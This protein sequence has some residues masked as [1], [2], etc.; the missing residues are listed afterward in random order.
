M[1]F[2][3]LNFAKNYPQN[4]T[5]IVTAERPYGWQK[6]IAKSTTYYGDF[7]SSKKRKNCDL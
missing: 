4:S 1:R 2:I 6:K 5:K 7:R 3:R